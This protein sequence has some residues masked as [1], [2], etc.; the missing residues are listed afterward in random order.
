M[1]RLLQ[2]WSEVGRLHGSALAPQPDRD[3][4]RRPRLPRGADGAGPRAETLGDPDRDAARRSGRAAAPPGAAAV[5]RG[6]GGLAPVGHLGTA[7]GGPVGLCDLDRRPLL[8]A[9]PLHRRSPDRARNRG[10]LA[11]IDT[12]RQ[13]GAP[14]DQQGHSLRG[15]RP[16]ASS[17]R[18]R[19]WAS[20][21][22]LSSP[23][24]ASW[25]SPF[26]SP[27]RTRSPT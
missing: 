6:L 27:P 11:H 21:S 7:H 17:S 12:A 10:R 13:D 26:R 4:G 24:P 19:S 3:R 22:R 18:S 25:D 9:E 16:S 15:H 20:T 5:E 14:D 2:L 8:P 23:A 1:E